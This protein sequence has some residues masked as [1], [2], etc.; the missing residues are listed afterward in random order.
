MTPFRRRLTLFWA[1]HPFVYF[2]VMFGIGG[3]AGS[4]LAATLVAEGGGGGMNLSGGWEA[5]AP[6]LDL[7]G[8]IPFLFLLSIA[9]FG[10]LSLAMGLVMRLVVIAN[11]RKIR[12]GEFG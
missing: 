3:V 4:L 8:P 12:A 2:A 7:V 6:V 10:G 5:L 11:A 1:D 9:A